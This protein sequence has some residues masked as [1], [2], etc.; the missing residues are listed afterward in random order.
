M[1]PAAMEASEP[2]RL[3]ERNLR[4]TMRYFS[5]ARPGAEVRDLPGISVV[6]SGV[7]FAV[8]NA[9]LLSSPVASAGNDLER[10]IASAARQ[11]EARRI[12]W[13]CWICEDL[14]PPEARRSSRVLLARYGFKLLI[15]PPGMY[16]PAILP[17]SR[18]LPELE[19]RR[20]E[21]AATRM[22]FC[23]ITSIAFELPFTIS[24]QIYDSERTWAD[25]FTGW[26]GYRRGVPV[27]T[28]ATVTAAETIG[29]YSVATLPEHQHR[30][31]AEAMV[32]HA[33]AEARRTSGLEG[34]VLLRAEG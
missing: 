25:G 19:M 30:G 6:Y 17:Q 4:A 28:A 33:I 21:D 13:S 32:R 16:A 5:L 23:N 20:V 18:P 7:D 3:V 14:L 1:V 26:V 9:A 12:R 34:S 15:E 29:L 11:F 31:Y 22:A 10:R 27:S 8:F 2:Y 24:R